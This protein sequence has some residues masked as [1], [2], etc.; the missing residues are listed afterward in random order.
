MAEPSGVRTPRFAIAFLFYI[1]AIALVLS[2]PGTAGDLAG[3]SPGPGARG[4]GGDPAGGRYDP[5][6]DVGALVLER[7]AVNSWPAY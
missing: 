7:R 6:A 5:R 1:P 4:G 2:W 3:D